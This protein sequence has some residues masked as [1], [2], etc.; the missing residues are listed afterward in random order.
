MGGRTP[1]WI[2]YLRWKLGRKP[3]DGPLPLEAVVIDFWV[4]ARFSYVHEGDVV[5][6]QLEVRHVT[7]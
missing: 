5:V 7:C 3:V 6:L 4:N 2:V 1:D